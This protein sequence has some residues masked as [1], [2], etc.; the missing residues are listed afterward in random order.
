MHALTVVEV[1]SVQREW[2]ASSGMCAICDAR[3]V[4]GHV[5]VMSGSLSNEPLV[6]APE[7]TEVVIV[8][9]EVVILQIRIFIAISGDQRVLD[10]YLC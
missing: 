10:T 5:E 6:D 2:C 3:P 1:M 4:C 8:V 9:L 7:D